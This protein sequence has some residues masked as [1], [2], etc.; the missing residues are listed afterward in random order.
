MCTGGVAGTGTVGV[1]PAFPARI[2]HG[3]IQ[4]ARGPSRGGDGEAVRAGLAG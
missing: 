4:L 2:P 1:C 3:V